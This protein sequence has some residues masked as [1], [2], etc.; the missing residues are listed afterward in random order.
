[1]TKQ[2]FLEPAKT[3][4]QADLESARA[5]QLQLTKPPGSLGE[6]EEIAIS[7]CGWQKTVTPT[8]ENIQITIF[9]A[10]HGVCAQNVSAFPQQ[11]TAQMVHNFSSGGAAISVLA[12]QIKADFNVINLGLVSEL[13]DAPKL[14]N[15]PLMPGTNDFSIESAMSRE[16]LLCALSIGREAIQASTQLFIGGDMGIGNTT[17]ASAIYSVLLKE[18][19]EST[20]GP[21]TGVDKQGILLKRKVLY[22]AFNLH[23]EHMEHPLEVLQH[24]GG[25]EIAGLVGAYIACAQAGIPIL[26]DGFISTAAALAASRIN[27]STLEWMIFAH[28]SA[29]PA[30]KLALA[31]LNARPLLDL[32]MRLGEGSGA[33]IAAPIIINAVSL[34]NNMATFDSAG[35][36]DA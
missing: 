23:G 13:E 21:G 18:P 10:D 27:P 7:F 35:V 26:I 32:N 9:A 15:S 16:T 12:K 31:S 24:V 4:D 11:V 2:W 33:A 17:S 19:P 20:V 22:K 36:S 25:L 5:H 30:H 29:E 34:H 1:M 6:L 28:K 14:I 3:I 8:C